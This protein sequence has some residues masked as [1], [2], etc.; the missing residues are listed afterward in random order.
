MRTATQSISVT[1]VDVVEGHVI[2]PK[3]VVLVYRCG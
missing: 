1:V 2:P 3:E